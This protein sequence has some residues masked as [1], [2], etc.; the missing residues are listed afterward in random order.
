MQKTIFFENVELDIRLK[1]A[2]YW[3]TVLQEENIF[4]I[5][6]D[7]NLVFW[8]VRACVCVSATIFL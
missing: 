8:C 3:L 5:L 1:Y 2:R 7:P 6:L 4:F